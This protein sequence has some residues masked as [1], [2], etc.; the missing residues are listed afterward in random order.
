LHARIADA[1]FRG[2]LRKWP[3]GEAST[4]SG[5]FRAAGTDARDSRS[6][7]QML[8]QGNLVKVPSKQGN[9]VLKDLPAADTRAHDCL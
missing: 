4:I 2:R 1:Q 7:S 9:G 6:G 3:F 8:V 5:H